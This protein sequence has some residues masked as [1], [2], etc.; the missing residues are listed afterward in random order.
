VSATPVL[1]CHALLFDLDGVLVDSLPSVERSWRAWAARHG[2]DAEAL[3]PTVHGRR[4][5]DTIR[6]TAPELDAEAELAALVASEATDTADVTALPGAAEL[7]SALPPRQWAVVTSGAPPVALARLRSAGLPVPPVLI[8]ATDVG[9]GK[10][11]PEGYLTAAVRLGIAPGECV[12][13]EDAPAGVAAAR[14][15]RMRVVAL[16]TTMPADA[17]RGADVIVPSL[18]ALVVEVDGRAGEPARLTVSAV[19]AVGPRA[20]DGGGS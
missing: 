10:P 5:I 4:A 15:G 12:V 3:L 8:T 9:R 16:T 18:A 20:G 14:A 7:I 17:L 1:H 6:A 11:D 2:I 19:A 13:V